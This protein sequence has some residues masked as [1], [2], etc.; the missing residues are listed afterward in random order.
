MI[1]YFTQFQGKKTKNKISSQP[2]KPLHKGRRERKQ[3]YYSISIK[4]ECDT[5]H[6]QSQSAKKFA[7]TEKKSYPFIEP[8]KYYP[9]HTYFQDKQLVLK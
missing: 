1:I 7:K 8:S 9:L 2:K 4:P 6:N 5:H 3:F